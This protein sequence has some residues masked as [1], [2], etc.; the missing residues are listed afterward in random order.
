MNC[1]KCGLDFPEKEIDVSHDV[2]C[3]I[4]PGSDRK[5]KKKIADKYGRHNLCKK[6]HDIYEKIIFSIMI[7]TLPVETKE[8]M[9]IAAKNFA[10]SYFKKSE[11]KEYDSREA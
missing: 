9:I 10:A 2:P 3:Y 6:C 8:S 4:F 7:E 5:E 1:Q 11:V